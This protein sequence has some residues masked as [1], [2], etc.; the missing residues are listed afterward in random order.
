MTKMY[1]IKVSLAKKHLLNHPVIRLIELISVDTIQYT[2][3]M[4]HQLIK[5]T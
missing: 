2:S 1:N 3:K 5:R 4:S